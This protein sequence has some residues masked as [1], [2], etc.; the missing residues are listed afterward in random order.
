VHIE[1]LVAVPFLQSSQQ[2]GK[3]V[4]RFDVVFRVIEPGIAKHAGS[5]FVGGCEVGDVVAS[6][7]ESCGA[8]PAGIQNENIHVGL[9]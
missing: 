4:V 7:N 2:P 3:P 8:T 6:L 1:S 9:F 5:G